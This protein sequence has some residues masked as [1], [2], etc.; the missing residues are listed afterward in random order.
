MLVCG[1]GGQCIPVDNDFSARTS[2]PDPALQVP[3]WP[4][5]HWKHLT[6]AATQLTGQA[7]P[8]R[9]LAGLE[10]ELCSSPGPGDSCAG[11]PFT[12]TSLKARTGAD[13][14]FR[15]VGVPD[16][17]MH[18]LVRPPEAVEDC[19]TPFTLVGKIFTA[20]RDCPPGPGPC[21][22]GTITQCLPFEMPPR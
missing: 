17:Q 6:P 14:S 3:D 1:T 8:L 18:L 19:H 15:F 12:P 22:L 9:T 11:A 13:G 20:G 5:E 2:A 16:G 10:I 4:L 7:V 21:D